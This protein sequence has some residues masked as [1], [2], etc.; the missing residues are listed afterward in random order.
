MLLWLFW[1][2]LQI[3]VVHLELS[4]L[5]T[6]DIRKVFGG[7]DTCSPLPKALR[8]LG[9]ESL[10]EKSFLKIESDLLNLDPVASSPVFVCLHT[11][12][13]ICKTDKKATFPL[14]R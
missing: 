8:L 12:L 4:H 10:T 14:T 2:P 5:A 1:Q 13:I 6:T 7:Q 11:F 3:L 9:R